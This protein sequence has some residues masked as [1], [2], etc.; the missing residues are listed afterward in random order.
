[1]SF[2]ANIENLRPKKGS[3]TSNSII[4]LA[5][6]LTQASASLGA[7]LVVAAALG[8]EGQGAVERALNLPLML[9]PLA[10]MTGA[11]AAIALHGRQSPTEEIVGTLWIANLLGITL[12]AL[13]VFALVQFEFFPV[14]GHLALAAVALL[15]FFSLKELGK[16]LSWI[17]GDAASDNY[18]ASA[19]SGVRVATLLFCW[20]FGWLT[21]ERVVWI[22]VAVWAVSVVPYVVVE[23]ARAV[24]SEPPRWSRQSLSEF[25]QI[26]G[27]A[28]A[29]L[30]L[31]G[32]LLRVDI[33]LLDAFETPTDDIG[34]YA[35]GVR[36]AEA[37]WLLPLAIAQVFVVD[38]AKS[39]LETRSGPSLSRISGLSFGLVSVGGITVWIFLLLLVPKIAPSY[40]GTERLFLLLLPGIALYSLV[41]I[42]RNQLILD[43]RLLTLILCALAAVGANVGLNALLIPRYGVSGA[44]CATTVAYGVLV[45]GIAKASHL[46]ES[47][48]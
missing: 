19:V 12:A 21:S 38:A 13:T 36:L 27:P 18:V 20:A 15:T 24:M 16:A 4:V 47:R 48:V 39:R 46:G 45:A 2:A 14:S 31:V 37:L 41:P 5:A 42:A 7:A 40:A 29:N 33:L 44:A 10:G 26:A 8:P 30:V 25:M 9:A 17:R 3:F 32:M 28:T 43:G 1:V 34:R 22:I 6:K 23:Q 11:H 35:M